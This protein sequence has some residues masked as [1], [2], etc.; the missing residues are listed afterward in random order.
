[1]AYHVYLLAS[2]KEGVLYIGVTGDLV[3]RVHQHREKAAA[4][5][6]SRYNVEKLV[7]FESYDDPVAAITREKELKKWRRAWKIALIEK[8]NRIGAISITRL[9]RKLLLKSFRSHVIR[10]HVIPGWSRRDQT[11][12]DNQTPRHSGMARRVRPGISRRIDRTCGARFR[13][14][15]S[16]RPGMTTKT[17]TR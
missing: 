15:R 10:P 17:T 4:G 9:R 6:T 7:W 2:R 13:V 1:M 8:D 3:R 12:N 16:A 11:R 14:R 5:F